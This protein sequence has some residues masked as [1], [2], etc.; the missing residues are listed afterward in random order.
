V[1]GYLTTLL[2][3]MLIA[4]VI[5]MNVSMFSDTRWKEEGLVFIFTNRKLYILFAMLAALGFT[6][7]AI[8]V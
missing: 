1:S 7:F 2:V 4:L 5:Y 8:N 3:I 6:V